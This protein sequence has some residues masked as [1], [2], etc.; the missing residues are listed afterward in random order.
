[1][2][3]QACVLHGG[4]QFS[5]DVDFAVAIDPD[6]LRQLKAAL[7]ELRARTLY[8]PPLD[9][10]F[11]ARGHACHFRCG[12]PGVRGLR[13]DVMGRMRGADGFEKL[14]GRR[15]EITRPGIGRVALVSL[16]D[17]V[18]I[19]KTQRDK[20]WLMIRH[21]VEADIVKARWKGSATRVA[22]WIEECRSVPVLLRL[23]G[24][25]P[26]IAATV[27][28]KRRAAAAAVR[29][30]LKRTE[31]LL[32]REEEV[33]RKLDQRYWAPLRRELERWRLSR[34]GGSRSPRG[35]RGP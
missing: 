1:M 16:P 34:R 19:K 10:S 23:V 30:R 27:A 13:I 12:A 29:G 18:R 22:F 33:E 2:G 31:Q 7:R 11:L 15:L 17:L 24:L 21:I 4:V 25:H 3:G 28:R 32:R 9:A 26:V 35:P 8:Y 14:W 20:D 5:R 6:N